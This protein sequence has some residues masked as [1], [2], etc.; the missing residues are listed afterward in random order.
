MLAAGRDK[1][2]PRPHCPSIQHLPLN[3][4]STHICKH[5]HTRANM[6]RYTCICPTHTHKYVCMDPTSTFLCTQRRSS[7]DDSVSEVLQVNKLEDLNS[8]FHAYIKAVVPFAEAETWGSLK[9]CWPTNLPQLVS[10]HFS[11]RLS[12]HWRQ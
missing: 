8:I 7:F 10:S 3:S 4:I 1:Q 12:P 6:I 11:G 9:A 2:I 5:Q